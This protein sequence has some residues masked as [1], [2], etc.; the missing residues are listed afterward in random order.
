MTWREKERMIK[1]DNLENLAPSPLSLTLY[2]ASIREE[3]WLWFHL[4]CRYTFNWSRLHILHVVTLCLLCLP[5]LYLH[6]WSIPTPWPRV[7]S[8]PSLPS[9]HPSPPMNPKE[10]LMKL[11]TAFE[12]FSTR[13]ALKDLYAPG[14]GGDSRVYSRSSLIYLQACLT[15]F[16]AGRWVELVTDSKLVKEI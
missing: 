9:K 14:Y 2:C 1:L 4:L 11:L 15:R 5:I 13:V 7:H 3:L 10:K 12:I 6:I 16:E 8:D